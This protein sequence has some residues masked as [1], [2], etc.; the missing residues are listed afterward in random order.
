MDPFARKI[1]RA[2]FAY[3]GMMIVMAAA[4]TIVYLHNRPR[5]GDRIVS[6][7]TSPDHRWTATI[8]E[9][10]CGDDAP[11]LTQINVRDGG[12][13]LK[14]GYISGQANENN[15]FS[16]EQDAAETGLKFNWSHP[17]ELIVKCAHCDPRYLH[18]HQSQHGALAIRYA[19]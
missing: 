18:Q 12:T 16:I 1:W 4:L 5:C 6:E 9:R 7:S 19:L 17:G 2:G 13:E 10:R 8:L 11:F 15:V 3:G 14:R